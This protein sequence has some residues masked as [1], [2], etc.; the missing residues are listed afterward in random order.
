MNWHL[1]ESLKAL[2]GQAHMQLR[3]VPESASMLACQLL[4]AAQGIL[5]HPL[6]WAMSKPR[7]IERKSTKGWRMP[8]NTV[9]V[10]RGSKWGN[11]FPLPHQM[12]YGKAWARAAYLQWLRTSFYGMR[13]MRDHLT[14]LRGKNLAC[15]CKAGEAC[16]ADVLLELSNGV[17]R[18]R[19]ASCPT[20][21]RVAKARTRAASHL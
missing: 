12:H 4:S 8:P 20:H 1:S 7:R 19:L 6:D 16:H 21:V 5:V 13:L 2:V 11:P 18:T 9:Y 14:E 15:W 10:G 3:Q 17:R